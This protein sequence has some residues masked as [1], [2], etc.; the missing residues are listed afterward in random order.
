MKIEF[1]K[2]PFQQKEFQTK[3]QNLT[4]KGTFFKE[5]SNIAKIEA[6][7]NGEIEVEC[8]KCNSP[9]VKTINE[10]LKLIITN[11]IFNGFD[12][13]YDV[14][15]IDSNIV[16]FDDIIASEIESEKLDF[17]NI[18]NKCKTDIVNIEY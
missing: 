2:I 6:I 5:S 14:I 9:F 17:Q 3:F 18:C 10:E 16:N 7:L 1:R 8:V 4:L 15:E 11:Q 12:E 13:N